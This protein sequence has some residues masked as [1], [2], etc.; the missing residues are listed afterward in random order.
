MVSPGMG[1]IADLQI[2][3]GGGGEGRAAKEG[4]CQFICNPFSNVQRLYP[5]ANLTIIDRLDLEQIHART[6]VDTTLARAVM[7]MQLLRDT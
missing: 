4:D 3:L 2:G 1:E 6:L 7:M 5:V